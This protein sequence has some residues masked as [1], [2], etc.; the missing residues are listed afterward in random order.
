MGGPRPKAP[1]LNVICSTED[2][3]FWREGGKI[4]SDYRGLYT[5]DFDA[6]MRLK[7]M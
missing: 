3:T 4:Y 1:K 5:K 6:S 7:V 2:G